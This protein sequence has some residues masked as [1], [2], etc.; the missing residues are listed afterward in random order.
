MRDHNHRDTKFAAELFHQLKNL[1]LNGHIQRSRRLVRNQQPRVTGKPDGDHHPLPHAARKLV[2]VLLQAPLGVGYPDQPQKL[3]R[4]GLLG[5]FVHAHVDAQGF[6][7]LVA[8][9]QN[10]VQRGHRFL[11]DHANVA[12]TDALHFRLRK[13][14]QILT[15]EHHATV[16]N[17]GGLGRQQAHDRQSRNRFSRSA[18]AYNRN[19]FAGAHI[20][21]HVLHSPDK[22][23]C[24][25]KFDTQIF[26]LQDRLRGKRWLSFGCDVH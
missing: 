6:G 16:R 7:Q 24:R 23:A 14:Q 3:N 13:F 20:V 17:I 4:A 26:D 1:R 10:R 22:A 19:H 11:K 2:R 18:F 12:P 8:D 9:R 5:G 21:G 15:I 25:A